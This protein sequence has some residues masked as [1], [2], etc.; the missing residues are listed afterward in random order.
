MPDQTYTERVRYPSGALDPP[1]EKQ[2]KALPWLWWLV[3]GLTMLYFGW[4]A[5]WFRGRAPLLPPPP[6]N[7]FG[8]S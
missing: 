6:A 2:H 5:G 3:I 1:R 7:P 4:R 8:W